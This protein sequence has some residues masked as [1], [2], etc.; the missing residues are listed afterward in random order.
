MPGLTFW[1]DNHTPLLELVRKAYY[2][3]VALPDFQRNFVW[4]RRNLEDW[5][6][7]MLKGM[8]GG[9]FLIEE[10]REPHQPFKMVP[11]E[12]VRDVNPHY[13]MRPRYLLLDGQQRLTSTFYAIYMP[14]ISLKDTKYSYLYFIDLNN[15]G[16]EEFVI[17]YARNGREGKKYWN[18]ES[19]NKEQLQRDGLIPV[20]IFAT[21]DYI[22]YVPS[23]LLSE[24][25]EYH[26]RFTQYVVPMFVFGENTDPGEIVENFERLNRGGIRLSPFDLLNARFYRDNLNIR[27]LWKQ[28]MKTKE[29]I[30]WLTAGQKEVMKTKLAYY[31]LQGIALSYGRGIK[32][33]DMMKLDT[34]IINLA[35][36]QKAID[37]LDNKVLRRLEREYGVVA[38]Q[39]LPSWPALSIWIGIMLQ[40]H[41][42][43]KKVGAWHWA[44]TFLK[45]YAGSGETLRVKDFR[46]LVE[47]MEGG[48]LP[49]IIKDLEL[50]KID[51][52][53]SDSSQYKGVFNLLFMRKAYDFYHYDAIPYLELEDHHIF[54]KSY[55]QKKGAGRNRN[56]VLNRTLISSETNRKIS[57]KS[58]RRYLQEMIDR[59]GEETVRE[60]L[61]RHFITEE[62]IELMKNADEET[63]P[64]DVK[65][66]FESFIQLREK[67]IK[68]EIW[69][70]VEL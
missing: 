32:A 1:V 5:L 58:P 36:W 14:D 61:A 41:W 21:D 59:H 47:W 4:K 27:E 64:N 55:L 38:P 11:I 33:G 53:Y 66:I 57:N 37:A 40:E 28:A 26:K 17:S 62:M 6:E 35:N 65:E 52:K 9:T 69:R 19:W 30:A 51:A 18:G 45:R 2:G 23:Q 63:L 16:K 24:V 68:K 44:S 43:E 54:P 67:E 20:S 13:N 34:T 48:P 10:V 3:E 25:K 7:T 50:L 60:I 29:K 56:I 12:G 49:S 8:V 15:L 46:E 39:W 70:L 31:V 22:D 42:D